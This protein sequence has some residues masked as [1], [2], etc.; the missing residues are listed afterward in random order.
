MQSPLADFANTDC[1]QLMWPDTL[2]HSA[3]WDI[4]K[5][6][7]LLTENVAADVIEVIGERLASITASPGYY[8]PS[9]GVSTNKYGPVIRRQYLP[10]FRSPCCTCRAGSLQA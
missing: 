9:D 10:V 4:E 7:D 5:L 6:L 2:H 8:P 1:F 3:N